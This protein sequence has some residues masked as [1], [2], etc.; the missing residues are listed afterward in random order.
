MDISFNKPLILFIKLLTYSVYF[1]KPLYLLICFSS[2]ML[3]VDFFSRSRTFMID[4]RNNH[5]W[6]SHLAL[7]GHALSVIGQSIL[8]YITSRCHL[9]WSHP[10]VVQLFPA[11]CS[12]YIYMLYCYMYVQ[13]FLSTCISWSVTCSVSQLLISLFS[14]KRFSVTAA[15]ADISTVVEWPG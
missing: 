7:A 11:H 1:I 2:M 14:E 10:C 12:V 9:F 13:L 15:G 6:Q 5:S 8:C 3:F 4:N